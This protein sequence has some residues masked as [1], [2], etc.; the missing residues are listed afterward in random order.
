MSIFR[1]IKF[2]ILVTLFSVLIILSFFGYKFG[3]FIS[4]DKAPDIQWNVPLKRIETSKSEVKAGISV[5]SFPDFDVFKNHF[6]INATVWFEFNP[7]IFSLA[8]IGNF[9]FEKGKILKKDKPKLKLLPNK[10]MFAAYNVNVEFSSNLDFREFP[11]NDH[12]IFL[13][14]VNDGVSSNDLMFSSNLSNFVIPKDLYTPDWTLVDEHVL[15]GYSSFLYS[16]HDKTNV[17]SHPKVIYI[18]DFESGAKKLII[19]V[20]PILFLLF[21]SL[22]SLTINPKDSIGI[23]IGS[24]T[25]LL[26]YNFVIMVLSPSVGYFMLIDYLYVFTISVSFFLLMLNLYA[27]IHKSIPSINIFIFYFLQLISIVI[28]Y[29]FIFKKG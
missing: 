19:I 20:V 18:F 6:V 17:T 3:Q 25:A 24:I 9:S 7:V 14:L 4:T 5:H 22:F 29:Y 23:S 26:A 15:T 13:S 8:T 27:L 21:M 16:K 11:L 10:M 2:Q 28:Y 12:K 1:N